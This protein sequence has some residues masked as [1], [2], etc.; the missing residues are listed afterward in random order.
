[1]TVSPTA[2]L[3]GNENVSEEVRM[4]PAFSL[5]PCQ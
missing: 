4:L 5:A 1:M 2:R 3:I